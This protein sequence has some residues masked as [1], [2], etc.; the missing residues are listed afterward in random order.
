VKPR[1][2]L[3]GVG[4]N[5]QDHVIGLV[6]P[7]TI[8]PQ[9]NEHLTYL[10][11]RDSSPSDLLQYISGGT[12]P[13]SQAGV[14]ASGFVASNESKQ[15]GRQNG[16]G[17]IWPDLQLILLGIPKDKEGINTLVK[18]YNLRKDIGEEFYAPVYGQ[19]SFHVMSIA[20]RPKSRGEILLASS[21]PKTPPLID[22]NYYSDPEDVTKTIEGTENERN[23]IW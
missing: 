17:I 23:D 14:L 11:S 22:P 21:D 9:E 5:L 20:S 2:H 12:G 16:N 7:F 1:V 3:P 10:P 8:E 4:K 13:L 6:G 19:D 15:I 18:V